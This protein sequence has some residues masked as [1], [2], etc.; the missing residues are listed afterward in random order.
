MRSALICRSDLTGLGFQTRRLARLLNPDK[1]LLIH[2]TIFNGNKQHPS[3]YR[4]YKTTT[5]N[6]FIADFEVRNFLKDVDVVISCEL[7]YNNNFT[8]IAKE[9]GVKTVLISNIEFYDWLQPSWK[10][11]PPPDKVIVPTSWMIDKIP[12]AEVLPT[13]IFKNEF[14]KAYKTNVKRSGKPQYLFINGKSA[15]HDRNGLDSLYEAL[16]LSKGDYEI[17][18]KSQSD[19]KKHPDP[20]ITYDFSNP[21][22][23]YKLYEDFDALILPRRYA[24]Q[25]LPMCEALLSGL[26]VIM[27]DISPNNDYLPKEWLVPAIKTG[28]FMTR[29]M[30][31]IYSAD[32]KELAYKLDNFKRDP[33]RAYSI[34]LQFE[35]ENLRE[36]YHKL[37]A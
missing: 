14:Q 36:K 32:I 12:G 4:D 35:S 15:I 25:S 26:P 1:V 19:I 29:T 5:I 37:L 31:D 2:S 30:V 10:D 18:I 28:Q 6:G 8:R 22:E 11:A 24:G 21:E 16:K 23:Q 34:G 17:I 9:M 20:R 13:P 7:F 3:W 33:E 27:T